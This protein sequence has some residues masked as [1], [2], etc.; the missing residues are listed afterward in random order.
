MAEA[1]RTLSGGLDFMLAE[2]GSNFS[3]GQ[4]QLICLSRAILV[5]SKILIMDESAANV[6]SNTDKKLNAAVTTAFAN[7]TII[8]IA[9][10]LDSIIDYDKILVLGDGKVLEFGSPMELVKGGGVFLNMIE[11]T[12]SETAKE[13]KR[14]ALANIK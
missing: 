13:L 12:G 3:V 7:S 6:D 5:K 1:V 4:Q 14:R 9:H 8:S 2:G 10:R 11:E